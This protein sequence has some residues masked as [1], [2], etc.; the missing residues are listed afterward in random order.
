MPPSRRIDAQLVV[1]AK[2][3]TISGDVPLLLQRLQGLA[4]QQ[5][6]DHLA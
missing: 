1:K 3:I 2:R 4:A 6:L 5:R